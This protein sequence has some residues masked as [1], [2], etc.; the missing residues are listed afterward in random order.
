MTGPTASGK[1]GLLIDR[2]RQRK[3]LAVSADSR[4][5]FRHMNIGTGKPTPEEQEILPHRLIDIAD[6]AEAF[7]VH[8]FLPGAVAAL[9]EA[10]GQGRQ[11]W[12]VGGTGLYIKALVEGLTLGEAP[13]PRLRKALEH[14]LEEHGARSTAQA[15]GVPL[16]E[17]DNPVRVVRAVENAC[18]EDQ[19][20]LRLYD[21]L[22]LSQ[23]D[24]R[25]DSGLD[26]SGAY[27]DALEELTDWRCGGIV[28]VDPG[29]EK[30]HQS[31]AARVRR[32][33]TGGIVEEV[34]ELRLL[35][36]GAATVVREGIGY[37]EAGLLLDG[38]VSYR[39][40]I[41]ATTVRTKQYAKRQRTFI[42]SQ[43]W[44]VIRPEEFAYWAAVLA[45]N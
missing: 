17:P 41:E 34:E 32:M 13:H 36:F 3:L 26:D 21:A 33:F 29:R 44:E 19:A 27:R 28:A 7:S 1:T 16:D 9:A 6:P 14:M 15:L 5:V 43:G 20:A 11:P 22:G 40:A 35:G 30:L 23:A 8:R 2:A 31:I 24:L 45:V 37:R 12:L 38:A 42:R 18:K 39:Q 4:Q 10:A 25:E